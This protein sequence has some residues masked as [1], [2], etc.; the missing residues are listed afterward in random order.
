MHKDIPLGVIL[1]IMDFDKCLSLITVL[2][3]NNAGERLDWFTSTIALLNELSNENKRKYRIINDQLKSK[4]L[5]PEVLSRFAS[6]PIDSDRLDKLVKYYSSERFMEVIKADAKSLKQGPLDILIYFNLKVAAICSSG[7]ARDDIS[8]I[9]SVFD[10]LLQS[11]KD[12]VGNDTIP[13][14]EELEKRIIRI[15]TQR[16]I[17]KVDASL[18]VISDNEAK[19]LIE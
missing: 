3:S 13:N 7:V 15:S 5:E 9:T 19:L 6:Y 4:I 16:E 12:K 10:G 1:S 18:N 2:N 14:L 11:D 17:A 8:V